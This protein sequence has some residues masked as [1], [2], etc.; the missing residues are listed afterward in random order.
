LKILID[1]NI[2]FRAIPL[3][4]TDSNPNQNNG[5]LEWFHVKSFGLESVS[6][7]EI[8]NFAK[9]QSFDALMSADRDLYNLLL[10]N[11]IPPKLIWLRIGN[12]S[13][14]RIASVVD[15]NRQTIIN[16]LN[17]PNL[18]CLEIWP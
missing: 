18:E 13:Y 17:G 7:L 6:D 5:L 11:G 2:S 1:Q 15:G 9:A 16:F 3:L 14:Q 8:W 10:Q 12:G 4:Q